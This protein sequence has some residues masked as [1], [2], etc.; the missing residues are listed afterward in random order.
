M[1][2]YIHVP[3]CNKICSYCDFPKV[4]YN[5]KY[6]N[7]YL[8]CLKEEILSR[9]SGDIVKSIFIGGGTPTCLDYNELEKLLNITKIFDI[10]NEYEFTIESNVDTLDYSKIE[11]L[12]RYGV[13]RVSLGVESFNNNILK[14]LNRDGTKD[15]VFNVV[16][17][18]KDKNINNISIDLMYGVNDD[19]DILKRDV[20]YFLKL[21]IPHVSFYS[22]IIEDNTVFKLQNR[23]YIDEDMEYKM[24]NYI[25]KVLTDNEYIHYETSNYAKVGFESIHNI[26]Y[27][28]NG[29]YYGFGLGAISFIDNYRVTNTKNLTKYLSGDFC[30]DKEY[31][32]IE[33]RI[34]NALILGLRKIKG[35]DVLDFKDKYKVDI[36]SLYN[37][38][39]L[40]KE[41]KLILEDG[42]LFINPKFYYLSNE[43]LLNFV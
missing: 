42:F 28:D 8:E 13:N 12:D 32:N 31:E 22:L 16:K 25:E 27:W 3:F 23:E 14:E 15:R 7:K 43:I 34:S 11:L 20:A 1:Y 29:S 35:I 39:E 40:I 2:I 24:Y 10:D 26:N 9:Y 4:L 19:M 41:N 37:I 33:T 30:L 21:D 5:K 18:L 6:I 17:L 38:E 36:V